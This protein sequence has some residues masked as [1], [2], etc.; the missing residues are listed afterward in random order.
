[1]APR[2]IR[3]S[4]APGKIIYTLGTSTR[5]IEEFVALLSSHGV[6]VAVDVRRFPSSRWEHFRREKLAG[7]LGEAGI[8]YIYMG[9]ELGGYRRGGYPD[10]TN[11]PVFQNGL[12]R[13]KEIAEKR[14]TAIICAERFP[15]RCHRRFIA[16]K[17]E[18]LGWQVRH[19][20]DQERD[21]VPKKPS[22][23]H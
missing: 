13:L 15:W 3:L 10:F 16:L 22:G 1:M 19:I 4:I 23:P 11:T 8:D 7:L 20:I 21:W 2:E 6:E 17:L 9:S 12:N 14:R 18:E 5:S